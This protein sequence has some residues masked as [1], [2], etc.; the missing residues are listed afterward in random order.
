MLD[1]LFTFPIVMIDG[2]NEE[3]KMRNKP[4]LGLPSVS[5]DDEEEYDMVFGEAEYPY[6]DFIGVEDRWL[7]STES[8]KKALEQKFEGCIV[9]FLHA[10]Q[11]LVPWSK[12]KFKAEIKRFQET[13]ELAH[14]PKQAEK[15]KTAIPVM[16]ITPD[17]YKKIM[18]DGNSNKTEG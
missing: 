18:E 17:Q 8:F 7:P 10:G 12:K 5:D 3:R 6:W 13:Y 14:P 4:D 9:R 11:L 15:P 16:T 2:D 1:E